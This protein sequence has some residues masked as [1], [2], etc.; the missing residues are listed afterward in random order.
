MPAKESLPP[1]EGH[2]LFASGGKHRCCGGKACRVT[3]GKCGG[4][5]ALLQASC[6]KC[7]RT[8]V[9]QK[10]QRDRRLPLIGS[11]KRV[12][13]MFEE[14]LNGV[15]EMNTQLDNALRFHQTALNLRAQR[16]ELLAAN[17][18]NADTP[19]YKA[20]DVDFGSTLKGA[21]Q[22]R[23]GRPIALT[24]SSEKHIG[25]T[26][27]ATSPYVLYRSEDQANVDGNT[28][29]M[30]VERA[31]FAENSVQYEASL[32]FING[33]LKTMQQAVSGQ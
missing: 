7:G 24:T 4:F 13:E 31:A 15:E 10:L 33:L 16:Q 17:I 8:M 20:R 26:A 3:A 23:V 12:T 2:L 19:N 28:V 1:V 18:A 6:L 21:L 30:D 32:T 25:A 27:A 14:L 22:G 29:N 9:A 5:A 11:S